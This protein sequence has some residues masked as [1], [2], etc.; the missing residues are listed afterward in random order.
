MKKS[1][2]AAIQEARTHIASV[3]VA[4]LAL[5]DQLLNAALQE[6]EQEDQ[7]NSLFH[8]A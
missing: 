1:P 4:Y 3:H 5:F 7:G 8:D 6:R 2:P